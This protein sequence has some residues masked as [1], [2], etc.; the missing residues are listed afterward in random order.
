M[1]DGLTRKERI[2]RRQS[3]VHHQFEADIEHQQD[4]LSQINTLTQQ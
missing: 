4:L 1:A 2:A 3:T